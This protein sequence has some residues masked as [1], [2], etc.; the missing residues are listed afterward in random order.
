[1][2]LLYMPLL[3]F[4][5]LFYAKNLTLHRLANATSYRILSIVIVDKRRVCMREL[6]E[7][8]EAVDNVIIAING[9]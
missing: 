5:I 4:L 3:T 6:L 2:R 8:F 1:M 9:Y 7:T